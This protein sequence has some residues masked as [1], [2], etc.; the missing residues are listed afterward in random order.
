[1]ADQQNCIRSS[2]CDCVF[3]QMTHLEEEKLSKIPTSY[4]MRNESPDFSGRN[5]PISAN[6]NSLRGADIYD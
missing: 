1:M 2:H 4:L 6:Q 3:I 5:L